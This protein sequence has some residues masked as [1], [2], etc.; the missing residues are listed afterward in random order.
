MGE[1]WMLFSDG[2]TEARD[3]NGEELTLEHEIF[4]CVFDMKERPQVPGIN[5][6]VESQGRVT[7]EVNKPGS[8]HVH[9][10]AVKDDN[11]RICMLIC[12][13]TDLGDGWE[14]E[15]DDPWYFKEF[16]EKLAYPM[17]VNIVFY[18]LTH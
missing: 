16:S 12:Y 4:H 11:G 15:G 17:G 14:R 10:R 3:T 8:R 2:I 1:L 7:W 13:N 9:Y 18:A 6:A 5:I